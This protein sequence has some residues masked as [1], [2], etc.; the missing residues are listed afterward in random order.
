MLSSRN[1]TFKN[2]HTDLTSFRFENVAIFCEASIIRDAYQ[3]LKPDINP[4]MDSLTRLIMQQEGIS[5]CR[6]F[7]ELPEKLNNPKQTHPKQIRQKANAVN[8]QLSNSESIVYGAMQ[9]MFNAKPDLVI[10][11]DNLL[12]VCEAKHTEPF[13]DEQ[14]KRTWNI[15]QVWATLLYKDIGFTELPIYTV[16]KLGAASFNPHINWTDCLKIS[17]NTYKENDRTRIAIEAGTEL[18]K[19]NKL[20]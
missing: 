20:E 14:L 1:L 16:F 19:R 4:F 7:S 12:L 13:D 17:N 6:L 15:A 11:I 10:V 5:D 9:G 18:L 8:I 3:N 2:G